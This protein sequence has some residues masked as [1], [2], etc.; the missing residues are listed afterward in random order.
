VELRSRLPFAQ[1]ERLKSPLLVWQGTA[2]PTV[3]IADTRRHVARARALGLPLEFLELAGEGHNFGTLQSFVDTY[4]A[5]FAFIDRVLG[6]R[7]LPRD[8]RSTP[9]N[10]RSA[11][12][13]SASR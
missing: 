11:S 12:A 6:R 7:A 3:P 8:A 13:H 1:L 2:D 4:R 5:E 10:A 9:S